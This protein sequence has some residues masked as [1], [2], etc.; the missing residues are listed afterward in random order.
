MPRL[1]CEPNEF[2]TGRVFDSVGLWLI[3]KP[4]WG[5]VDNYGDNYLFCG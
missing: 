4:E 5:K 1:L 3:I 2:S